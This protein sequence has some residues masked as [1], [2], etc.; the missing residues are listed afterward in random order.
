[1][2][3]F[4]ENIM[5]TKGISDH[6]SNPRCIKLDTNHSE[7]TKYIH[8][9]KISPNYVRY[10][11]N[12]KLWDETRSECF[13]S[14]LH[15]LLSSHIPKWWRMLNNIL[16]PSKVLLGLEISCCYLRKR[17]THSW[18]ISYRDY[19]SSRMWNIYKRDL[20]RIKVDKHKLR[21]RLESMYSDYSDFLIT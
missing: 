3:I 16:R 18:A 15:I 6:T 12:I 10:S 13:F 21:W 14:I 8:L 5:K 1:M 9:R 11:N 20:S 7:G 4:Y 2:A 19:S 17:Q